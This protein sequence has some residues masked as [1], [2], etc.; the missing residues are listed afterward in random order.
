MLVL[1]SV[2]VAPRESCIIGVC[3]EQM[4]PVRAGLFCTCLRLLQLRWTLKAIGGIFTHLN[5]VSLFLPKLII[6]DLDFEPYFH[7]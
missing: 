2:V 7:L 5:F 6:E 4:V 3:L 1:V